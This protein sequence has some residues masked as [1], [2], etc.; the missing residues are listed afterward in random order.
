VHS[1][2]C[3]LRHIL[4]GLHLQRCVSNIFQ[5]RRPFDLKNWKSRKRWASSHINI[6]PVPFACNDSISSAIDCCHNSCPIGVDENAS[7]SVGE[8]L[9]VILIY[10]FE[11]FCVPRAQNDRGLLRVRLKPGNDQTSLVCQWPPH[12]WEY[13]L[14]HLGQTPRHLDLH[15]LALPIWQVRHH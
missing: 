6:F 8:S 13:P 15:Q 1:C 2:Q 3:T 7:L 14:R 10:V 5:I 12:L 9:L 4:D 11:S